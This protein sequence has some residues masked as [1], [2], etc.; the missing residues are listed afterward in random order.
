MI[1]EWFDVGKMNSLE[2]RVS[3]QFHE[4]TVMRTQLTIVETTTL[5]SMQEFESRPMQ[6]KC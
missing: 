2:E 1:T 3:A 4:K 5:L 6:L